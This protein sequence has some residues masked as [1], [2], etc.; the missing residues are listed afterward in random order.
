[1]LKVIYL[2]VVTVV[3]FVLPALSATHPLR[4]AI[5]PALL[6]LQVLTLLICRISISEIVR[7]AWRLK[8]LFLFLIGCYTLLPPEHP[9][10][11]LALHWQVPRFG[12]LV[13][14]NVTGLDR[15]AVMCLQI[16][17]VLLASTMVRLTGRGDDLVHGLQQL[18]LPGLFVHSL[19]RTL[20]LL[21]GADGRSGRRQREAGAR[22]GTFTALKR[23]L[24]GDVGSF[25]QSIKANME[26]AAGQ[27]DEGV[28][29]KL[30]ARLAHDVAVVSGIALCMAS[31]K[32]LKILPGLP[33]AS[34]HKALLLFPLY[35]LAARLT[36]SRWGATAAG[37]IMGVIGFLQGDGRFGVLEVLKHIAPGLV[38]D[39]AYPL[40][41]RLPVWALGYCL[42][43]LV[44]AV[45]RTSTELVLVLLLGARAEI[46]LF[47]AAKL[48]PNLLAGFLSGFVTLFVLRVFS[49]EPPVLD[50]SE[51][52]RGGKTPPDRAEAAQDHSKNATSP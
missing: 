25:V 8:W 1:M 33:F 43:G 27:S 36:H 13:P 41:R 5:V 30:E 19:D 24:R 50:G 37:A 16:L 10:E 47:P 49:P 46:Y 42:L 3:T 7:P 31:F 45:A 38:I 34:G 11:D 40:V 48:V 9:A 44:A 23:L 28:G 22:P 52:V 20:S 29:S 39:L 26:L 12:W 17:T 6:A 51:Q 14:F 32:M 15:A 4:W 18:R 21:S 2:L 35:V